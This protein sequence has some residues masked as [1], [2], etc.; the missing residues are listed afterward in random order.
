MKTDVFINIHN[1]PDVNDDLEI[2][3]YLTRLLSNKQALIQ[4]KLAFPTRY[5]ELRSFGVILIDADSEASILNSV[6]K[7]ETIHNLD[8]DTMRSI[9]AYDFGMDGDN[10]NV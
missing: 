5:E 9:F 10:E 4:F 1:L 2:I 6:T 3:E 8:M 7:V